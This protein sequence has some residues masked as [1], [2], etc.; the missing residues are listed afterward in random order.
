MIE[1]VVVVK[2]ERRGA[3]SVSSKVPS[4]VMVGI[5]VQTGNRI[6]SAGFIVHCVSAFPISCGRSRSFYDFL[7][8]FLQSFTP[9]SSR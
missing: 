8:S 6:P 1:V 2:K 3:F 9:C 7:G 5:E 4:S